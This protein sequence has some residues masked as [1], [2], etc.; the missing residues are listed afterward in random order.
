MCRRIINSRETFVDEHEWG[1]ES[2][3]HN[4]GRSDH[5]TNNPTSKLGPRQDGL[6]G[7]TDQGRGEAS[8]GQFCIHC[9]AWRGNYGLEPIPDCGRPLMELRD[10]L[11]EKE[12][13]YV[14]E[15]LEREGLL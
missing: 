9:N 4:P 10:D 3:G 13:Q 6:P 11:T 15:E 12:K 1:D 14:M 7:G 8:Q 5:G 2:K